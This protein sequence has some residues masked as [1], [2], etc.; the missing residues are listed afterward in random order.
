MFQVHTVRL[1]CPSQ[2]TQ[3]VHGIRS[4]THVLNNRRH[5]PHSLAHAQFVL[6]HTAL[7]KCLSCL[8]YGETE[9]SIVEV[10]KGEGLLQ[11]Q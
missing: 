7:L 6:S 8:L 3:S 1:R 4:D 5:T 11:N 2:D 9:A 10:Y